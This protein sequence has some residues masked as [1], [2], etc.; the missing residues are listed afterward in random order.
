[1]KRAEL[2]R[3]LAKQGATFAPGKGSHFHV[4]LNGKKSVLAMHDAD[5]PKGTY[6]AILKQLGL[7]G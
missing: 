1:M 4:Y 6:K 7:K 3:W 5:V 2:K